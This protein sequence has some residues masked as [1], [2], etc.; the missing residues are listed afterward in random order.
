MTVTT[1]SQAA[2]GARTDIWSEQRVIVFEASNTLADIRKKK[3]S[4][5]HDMSYVHK[6]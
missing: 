4:W 2:P 1:C 3:S 5:A 6:T